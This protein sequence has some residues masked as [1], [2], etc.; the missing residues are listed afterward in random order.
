MIVKTFASAPGS[1]I[2]DKDAA[3][4]GNFIEEKFNGNITS[5][6][7]I[8][9]AAAP[10][11][12]PI[13]GYFTWDR[14]EAARQWNLHEA[15]RLINAVM[16]VKETDEGPVLTRAFHYVV[17]LSEAGAHSGYITNQIVWEREEFADQV[18]ERAQKEFLSWKERYAQY[19]ELR[20]W[21]K[22]QL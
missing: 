20:H 12:S 15:R 11:R 8:V 2:S 17:E 19:S 5:A 16:E 9:S 13:H 21:A 14:D 7:Q 10:K 6:E 18:I 1:H 3:I 4:V 22:E